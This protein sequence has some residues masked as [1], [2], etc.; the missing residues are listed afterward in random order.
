MLGTAHSSVKRIRPASDAAPP[1]SATSQRVR[2]VLRATTST[3]AIIAGSASTGHPT[4]PA[5]SPSASDGSNQR[6]SGPCE[7]APSGC[8]DSVTPSEY[9]DRAPR[10]TEFPRSP[11]GRIGDAHGVAMLP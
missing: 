11:V 2:S 5:A 10:A 3:T 1:A 6:R 8:R 7:G 4:D 9:G